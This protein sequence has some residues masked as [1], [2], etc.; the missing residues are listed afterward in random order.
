[1][2]NSKRLMA[3]AI[4]LLLA[5]SMV[6]PAFAADTTY[7]LF[8][9]NNAENHT[10]DAYQIFQGDLSSDGT[11][12][13]NVDWGTSVKDPA[14]LIAALTSDTKEIVTNAGKTTLKDVFISLTTETNAALSLEKKAQLVAEI[15]GTVSNDS[16]TLDRFAELVGEVI[17]DAE[18]KFQSHKYLD[19][20]AATSG[21]QTTNDAGTKGYA[22][23]DLS[24]GYYLIKDK[25]NTL[26]GKEGDFYTK[27]IVRVVRDASIKPKGEGV[28]VE[29]TVNDTINGTFTDYED[30]N[31]NQNIFYKWE[32]TLPNNLSSYDEYNYKFIDTMSKGLAFVQFDQIYIENSNG[33]VAHTF[34]D[35]HDT[36]TENDTIPAGIIASGVTENADGSSTFSLE[37]TDLLK[38]YPS[39]IPSQKV[40]VKYSCYLTRD[41]VISGSTKNTV[42]LQYDNNPNGEG[43]GITVTDAAHAF[44][45]KIDIDKYDA[46]NSQTKLEGVEFILYYQDTVESVTTKHYALVVTE[47][48]VAA[49]TVINGK[50]VTAENIG[51]VY[52]YTDDRDEASILDTDANGAINLKGLD[53]GIYYLEETK[54]NDGYNLLD[55]PVQIEITPTY[56][57][58]GE[59]C[60]VTVNYE[61][62]GMEQGTSATVGVRNSKG[63][64]LP[65]TGGIGTT[66][67]YIVGAVLVVG[68][69]VF[70]V[71]KKRMTAS[72]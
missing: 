42:E 58:N 34:Y 55:T 13:S 6:A 63:S 69:V 60:D 71:T 66:I 44:T 14:A 48:M 16:T 25:D 67:F 9:E 56:N 70:L 1:M 50:Q 11:T 72:R 54:T 30:A 57:Q 36:E 5:V 8:I 26:D 37:F 41:A 22:I 31:T 45:F 19:A 65:S 21:A 40:V 59:E 61:V 2:K 62:D 28:S 49:N 33:S 18:G 4:C 52:G 38:L 12:L 29:K 46:A 7:D 53:Q 39:I 3:I 23:S 27:Y 43:T 47:E 51:L 15:L 10:Y 64:T 17:Y 68:A 24:A 35:L 32:G 20:A